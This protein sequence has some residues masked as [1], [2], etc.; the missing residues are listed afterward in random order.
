MYTSAE[1][2]MN[3]L[4]KNVI[5]Y[6][7]FGAILTRTFVYIIP[8]TVAVPRYSNN[9][10]LTRQKITRARK[11][12]CYGYFVVYLHVDSTYSTKVFEVLI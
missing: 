4:K 5:P 8:E 11:H 3:V 7:I 6:I 1:T 9:G 10:N 2:A 12:A